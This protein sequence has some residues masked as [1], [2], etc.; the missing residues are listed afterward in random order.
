[1]EKDNEKSEFKLKKYLVNRCEDPIDASFHILTW[2]KANNFKYSI[3]SMVARDILAILMFKFASKST[4]SSKGH[5]L[6]SFRIS[7][8][9]TTVEALICC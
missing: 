2:W 3:L 9:S 6:D 5:V 1:M 4:F 7:L 8:N